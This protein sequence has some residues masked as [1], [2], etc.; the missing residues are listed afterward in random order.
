MI[1]VNKFGKETHPKQLHPEHNKPTFFFPSVFI[2][3]F[4]LAVLLLVS[5]SLLKLYFIYFTIVFIFCFK[6]KV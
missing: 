4:G 2:L 1:Q 3:G 5:R 6:I